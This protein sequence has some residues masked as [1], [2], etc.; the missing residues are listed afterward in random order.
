MIINPNTN[1]IELQIRLNKDDFQLEF[2]FTRSLISE[3]EVFLCRTFFTF[4]LPKL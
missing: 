1:T 2:T 4:L 3:L